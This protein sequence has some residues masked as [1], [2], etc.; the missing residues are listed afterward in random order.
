MITD[1]Y[2][3]DFPQIYQDLVAHFPDKPWLRRV[4]GLKYQVKA[5]PMSREWL[6]LVNQ[7]AYGLA[8]FD[9]RGTD[10]VDFRSWEAVKHAMVFAA[11][12]LAIVKVE[13]ADRARKLISRVDGA[14]RNPDDMRGIMFELSLATGLY[15][16][17]CSIEWMEE[18]QGPG[19]DTFDML[20]DV[21]G[22]GLVEFECKS[23][24]VDKGEAIPVERALD[25]INRL[26]PLVEQE[27]PFPPNRLFAV[28]I[29]LEDT[30]PT[31]AAEQ[32][33][34]ANLVGQAIGRADKILDGIGRIDMQCVELGGHAFELG[35]EALIDLT[36]EALG[37]Q[38]AHQVIKVLPGGSFLAVRVWS[39][40]PSTLDKR[41]KDVAKKAI[42]RQMSGSRPG[43]LAMRVERHT[44]DG[45]TAI[46]DDQKN[47][48]AVVAT[49]L[50]KN[51]EHAHLA[52]VVYVSAPT[53]TRL[54]DS[55]VTG[56]STVYAFDN[57]VGAFPNL[58]IELLFTEQ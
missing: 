3:D 22:V 29:M 11:Q 27:F 33:I 51:A 39:V 44:G 34:L 43:C 14:L 18:D 50:M 7:V 2:Q 55:T 25:F 24:S 32:T 47:N 20:V 1:I 6:W 4:K 42:R 23:F 12:V 26:M 19:T 52:G 53:M 28:S 49:S 58:G 9:A 10:P 21:P 16:K 30:I 40:V 46:A 37:I 31:G 13:S 36:N 35:E 17:G 57:Q 48:L 54:S 5:N 56:Q 45:L 38:P 41:M 15:R 8:E